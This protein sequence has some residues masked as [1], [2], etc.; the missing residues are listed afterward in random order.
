[1]ADAAFDLAGCRV[2]FDSSAPGL[3]DWIASDLSCFPS[4]TDEGEIRVAAALAAPERG[5]LP[6]VLLRT[7]HWGILAAPPGRRTVWYPEG[8]VCRVDY[9]AGTAFVESADPELLKEL[10]YLLILSRAGEALDRRGLHRIHAGALEHR[11]QALLFCGRQGAG[12]STL[13]LELLK[14]PSFALISDDTPLVSRKGLVYPFPARV[15]LL[16]S[17]PHLPRFPEARRLVRRR[18]GLK[19]LVHPRATGRVAEAPVPPG[20]IFLLSKGPA[21]GI[22]RASPASGAAELAVSLAAGWGVPQL[23]EYFVRPSL[24]DI[25]AKAGILASRLR[26]AAA[27]LHSVPVWY[28]ETGPVPAANAAFL[29]GFLHSNSARAVCS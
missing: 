18:Y 13:L 22:R 7:G 4:H 19:H 9:A 20:A 6:P 2:R 25:A 14:D 23:A 12:K 17:S 26:A 8:A 10:S 28:F 11:G 29:S 3:T 5:S 1:M 16:D 24:G 15:G 21:P 27:L